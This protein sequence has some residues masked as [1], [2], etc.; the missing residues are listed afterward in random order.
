MANISYS[1]KKIKTPK[2]L[3]PSFYV[4]LAILNAISQYLIFKVTVDTLLL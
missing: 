2:P 4:K 1:G 3:S